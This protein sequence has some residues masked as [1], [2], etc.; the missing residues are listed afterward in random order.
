MKN[1]SQYLT[2][3]NSPLLTLNC[4]RDFAKLFNDKKPADFIYKWYEEEGYDVNTYSAN[5]QRVVRLVEKIQ[6]DKNIY[7]TGIDLSTNLFFDD[8]EDFSQLYYYLQ[9]EVDSNINETSYIAKMTTDGD[10]GY[11]FFLVVENGNK[12]SIKLVDEFIKNV[13]DASGWGWETLDI[14]V[15]VDDID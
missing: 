12:A 3:N 6:K 7:C 13:E 5:I 1:L 2:E 14:S 11:F 8:N 9:D 15:Y 10:D 4:A